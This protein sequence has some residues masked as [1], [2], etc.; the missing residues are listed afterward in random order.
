M[1]ETAMRVTEAKQQLENAQRALR[2]EEREKAKLQLAEVR[3]KLRE[4]EAAYVRLAA[5]VKREDSDRWARCPPQRDGVPCLP[6]AVG[7]PR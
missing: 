1:S 5:R 7:Q 3:T 4:A 2:D 6:Q